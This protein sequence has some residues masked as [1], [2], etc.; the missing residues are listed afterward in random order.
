MAEG[1]AERAANRGDTELSRLNDA[2]IV[3]PLYLLHRQMS[4][5]TATRRLSLSQTAIAS[6]LNNT[7]LPG[8]YQGETSS[9]LFTAIPMSWLAHFTCGESARELSGCS[10]KESEAK[11]ITSRARLCTV[12]VEQR[13][14]D[15]QHRRQQC[16]QHG[17]RRG[18]LSEHGRHCQLTSWGMRWGVCG[19]W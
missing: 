3:I 14:A 10:S 17:Q 9:S 2:A 7:I 1:F 16:G 8:Y 13:H 18:R 19:S 11:K 6:P 15:E 4:R 12:D 5:R